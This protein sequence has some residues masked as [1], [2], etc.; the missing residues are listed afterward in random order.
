MDELVGEYRLRPTLQL[1]RSSK[2]LFSPWTR[3]TVFAPALLLNVLVTERQKQ[4]IL[5]QWRWDSPYF[6]VALVKCKQTNKKGTLKWID[7]SLKFRSE[8]VVTTTAFHLFIALHVST[9]Y[10]KLWPGGKFLKRLKASQTKTNVQLLFHAGG[11][12]TPVIS[13]LEKWEQ[14]TPFSKVFSLH[15]CQTVSNSAQ[16]KHYYIASLFLRGGC[17]ITLFMHA[18]LSFPA[19]WA[20][21]SRR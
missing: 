17:F 4:S 8:V 11:K 6:T 14:S 7:F 18:A 20:N 19:L 21:S 16:N 5:K 12:S 15:S 9:V 2:S 13:V 3:L 1:R 10:F